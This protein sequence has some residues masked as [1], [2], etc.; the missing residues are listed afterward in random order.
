[1]LLDLALINLVVDG[2]ALWSVLLVL[3]REIL[4]VNSLLLSDNLDSIEV[5]LVAVA[6]I[7]LLGELLFGSSLDVVNSGGL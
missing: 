4:L 1:M 5:V 3:L 7:L 6:C 2:L